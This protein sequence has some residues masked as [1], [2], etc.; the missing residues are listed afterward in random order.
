MFGKLLQTSRR[1]LPVSRFRLPTVRC[2]LPL[3]RALER[4]AGT[5]LAALCTSLR[6]ARARRYASR[7]QQRRDLMRDDEYRKLRRALEEQREADL[8]L[9]RAG[10]RAKLHALDM[11]WE[12]SRVPGEPALPPAPETR[13]RG[14]TQRPAETEPVLYKAVLVNSVQEEVEAVLPRLPDVFDK[15]DVIRTLGWEPPRATLHRAL[16]KLGAER[17]IAVQSRSRGR[18]ATQYRKVSSS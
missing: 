9:I 13:P 15:Q 2:R 18:H 12:R 17:R 14:E 1:E 5:R 4:N 3:A 6:G 8:E 10:Y 7:D 16:A 11:L